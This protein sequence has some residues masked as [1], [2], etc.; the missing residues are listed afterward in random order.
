MTGYVSYWNILCRPSSTDFVGL[1]SIRSAYC[2]FNLRRLLLLLLLF[3]VVVVVVVVEEVE[4]VVKS[5]SSI[6]KK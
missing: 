6:S 2:C 5:S 1:D 3:V 4:V